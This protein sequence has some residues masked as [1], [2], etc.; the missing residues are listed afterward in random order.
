[1]RIA[2][3]QVD[4]FGVWN[5]LRLVE[6]ADN[7]TVFYGPNEAG[8]STLMQFLRGVLYGFASARRQ[9]YLEAARGPARGGMLHITSPGGE[10]FLSRHHRRGG[11]LEG[12]V[13]LS[14]PEGI[15]PGGHLLASLLG[16]VDEQTFTNVFAVGLREMQELA[17]LGDTE[18]ARWLYRLTSGVDRVS[19]VDVIREL[20]AARER[21]ISTDDKASQVTQLLAERDRLLTEVEEQSSTVARWVQLAEQRNR[22]ERQL[23]K[24]EELQLKLQ[25]DIRVTQTALGVYERYSERR[26]VQ[27]KLEL[28]G[29]RKEVRPEEL[30]RIEELSGRIKQR[31]EQRDTVIAELQLLKEELAGIEVNET[32]WEQAPKIEAI[33]EQQ[34]WILALEGQVQELEVEVAGLDTEWDK[35]REKLGL[36]GLSHTPIEITDRVETVLRGPAKRLRL[37]TQRLAQMEQE[38][39]QAP[40][41]PA[42]ADNDLETA[43]AKHKT[44]DLNT[45]LQIAS[46]RAAQLRRRIAIDGRLEQL[47]EHRTELE[48]QTTEAV[49]RQLMPVWFLSSL[50]GVVIFATVLLIAGFLLQS[51]S[52]LLMGWM[53]VALGLCGGM[54]KILLERSATEWLMTCRRR[55]DQVKK[56]IAQA[57]E[58][59]DQLDAELPRGGGPLATRLQA[60]DQ[61]LAALEALV[62]LEAERRTLMQGAATVD[63]RLQRAKEELQTARRLWKSALTEAGLPQD[64]RPR[65]V[66]QLAGQNIEVVELGRRRARRN[67]ELQQRQRDLQSMT[68]RVTQLIEAAGEKPQSRS[69]VELVRQLL[70]ALRVQEGLVRQRGALQ[71]RQRELRREQAKLLKGIRKLRRRRLELLREAEC[72]DEVEFRL[73]LEQQDEK[74]RLLERLQTLSADITASILLQATEAEVLPLLEEL[75][76]PQLTI[77]Q[78]S[79]QREAE[80]VLGEI[81]QLA[82]QRGQ[83]VLQQQTLVDDRR[84]PQRQ[85]EL[86]MIEKRLEVALA[87][88]RVQT[89]VSIL[90][91]VLRRQFEEHRQPETLVEASAYLQRLTSGHFTRVWTPLGD[92]VLYV[93]DRDGK[94]F[95]VDALSRGTREQLFLSLR[96]SLVALYARRGIKLPLILDDVL[97]NFDSERAKAAANVLRDFAKL[98]HQLLIFTCHEHVWKMFRHMK[99]DARKLPPNTDSPALCLP[100]TMLTTTPEPEVEEEIEVAPVVVVKK[101]KPKPKPLVI[102]EQELELVDEPPQPEP[103]PEPVAVVPPVEY[104]LAPEPLPEPEP[105]VWNYDEE[106]TDLEPPI[107]PTV[108]EPEHPIQRLGSVGWDVEIEEEWTNQFIDESEA[109]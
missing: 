98:G 72:L 35:Q 99:I 48:E 102:V 6:L 87:E 80:E 14:T 43:L 84:A 91:E 51:N 36:G 92:D 3:C 40:K 5:D 82:E 47:D 100:A 28:I 96:L 11:P 27:S 25:R 22:L 10:F 71:G 1:M 24:A 77:R 21:L 19:L 18:A 31:R 15:R 54:I 52:T 109:A 12:E 74:A 105:F 108:A 2:D 49:D 103:E 89:V 79:L 86:D 13:S 9:S 104:E 45:A 30:Q 4:G 42:S 23:A 83:V 73:R 7:L 68:L 46:E 93:D 94:S 107:A 41:A 59:R 81:R 50:G 88:W 97:V 63:S 95:I 67:E 20:R 53:L 39:S 26:I 106:P 101:P 32:L 58:E 55:L 44:K 85:F 37:A 33:G 8:K 16:D 34:A 70:A 56:Q 66:Q 62:P 75:E 78:S 29:P 90:L 76:A 69:T 61:E 64:L 60:A 57:T 17:T 38:A 65:Q